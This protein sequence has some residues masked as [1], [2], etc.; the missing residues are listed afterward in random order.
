MQLEPI[1]YTRCLKH[2][3]IGSTEWEKTKV[4]QDFVTHVWNG[5][6]VLTENTEGVKVCQNEKARMKLS[7]LYFKMMALGGGSRKGKEG[8]SFEKSICE[9][10]VA[11][12]LETTPKMLG[13]TL[14]ILQLEKPLL[15]IYS[16]PRSKAYHQ[17]VLF[18]PPPVYLQIYTHGLSQNSWINHLLNSFIKIKTRFP[19]CCPSNPKK[20]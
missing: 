6:I 2:R 17:R 15:S 20:P 9:T 4:T 3:V 11:T 1:N 16:L 13:H 7:D 19:E 12:I 10:K 18:P 8:N 5:A 14:E